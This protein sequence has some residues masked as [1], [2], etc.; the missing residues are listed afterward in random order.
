MVGWK[1]RGTL[2]L[3]LLLSVSLIAA[4]PIRSPAPAPRSLGTTPVGASATKVSLRAIYADSQY[5]E[6]NWTQTQD[7]CFKEYEFNWSTNPLSMTTIAVQPSAAYTSQYVMGLTGGTTYYFQIADV[8]CGGNTTSTAIYVETQPNPG[9]VGFSWVND[10]A[11][12]LHWTNNYT[13]GGTG[14]LAFVAYGVEDA[15]THTVLSVGYD[16]KATNYTFNATMPTTY[17][18]DVLTED[19]CDYCNPMNPPI[20]TSNAVTFT[21]TEP[22]AATATAT[23]T[24]GE[25]GVPVSF[26]CAASSGVAPYTY[27]WAF[28]D[29]ATGSGA[30]ASHTYSSAGSLSATCTVTDA[31][32]GT[33]AAHA[34][35]TVNPGI[36]VAATASASSIAPGGAV[37]FNVTA[38]GGTGGPYTITWNFGDGTSGTGS[39]AT[40]TYPTAG[41]YIPTV[42]VTD[43]LGGTTTKTLTAITVA[44]PSSGVGDL[45]IYAG[46]GVVAVVAAAGVAFL[47]LRRRKKGPATPPGQAPPS[48]P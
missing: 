19:T 23:P 28:G 5:F 47:L 3:V 20:F 39:T 21:T 8:D 37:I 7:A 11:V 18:L 6:V 35:V 2:A 48:S 31:H 12:H 22:V 13:Y 43:S 41:T 14:H 1:G 45:A 33:A 36:S 32:N 38:T 40:H 46:V 30:T 17:S 27:A 44:A 29:G 42:T 15:N 25:A 10:T 24:T 9:H 34:A 26:T 4:V 16:V